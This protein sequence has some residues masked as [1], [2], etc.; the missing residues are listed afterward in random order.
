MSAR[1]RFSARTTF[2]PSDLATLDVVLGERR[3][4]IG[5]RLVLVRQVE[6]AVTAGDAFGVLDFQV[7]VL[8]G[9]V[10]HVGVVEMGE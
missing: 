1:V 2:R 4:E 7:E 10:G 8:G 3:S 9:P 6:V 5:E